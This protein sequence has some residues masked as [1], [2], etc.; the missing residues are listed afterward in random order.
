[1]DKN[2]KPVQIDQF[3]SV[4]QI[5]RIENRKI[6]TGEAWLDLEMVVRPN[7]ALAQYTK[8]LE[9]PASVSA[10]AYRLRA[11]AYRYRGELLF[12][13]YDYN[14]A[15]QLEPANSKALAGRAS[16][17]HRQGSF[18]LARKDLEAAIKIKSDS[19][20]IQ[21]ALGNVLS[22]AGDTDQAMKAFEKALALNPKSALALSCIAKELA[23]QGK[24]AEAI[25]RFDQ[26]LTIQRRPEVE[27]DK[28]EVLLAQQKTNEAEAALKAL[29]KI[30]PKNARAWTLLGSLLAKA[31][32]FKD[33]AHAFNEATSYD[34]ENPVVWHNRGMLR[35]QSK[36]YETA[37]DDFNQA[38]QR[39]QNFL[40]S[41]IGATGVLAQSKNKV[42]LKQDATIALGLHALDVGRHQSA[43]AYATLATIY[44]ARDAFD[45][46]V[47]CQEKAI[48]LT[49]SQGDS[50]L[51]LVDLEID[52]KQYRQSKPSRT[53]PIIFYER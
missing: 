39:D 40:P 38:L 8:L 6:W 43:A 41:L 9:V 32:R 42:L 44:A 2:G 50:R 26:S 25:E 12:A 30:H 37:L 7:K 31:N 18:E 35:L 4:F 14:H 51:D 22:D 10:E 29:L 36:Y 46:A 3:T 11:E 49:K 21:I 53:D 5:D 48:A 34:S 17:Y 24:P 47:R 1:M 13:I 16:V 45:D 27:L 15:L 33:A 23:K 20:P 19:L 28:V 52:L